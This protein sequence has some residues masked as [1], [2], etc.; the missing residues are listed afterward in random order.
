MTAT[1]APPVSFSCQDNVAVVTIDSP[2]V[3]AISLAVTEGLG[4]ALAKFE[5]A[6]ELS[7]LVVACAGRTWV[8]GGDIAAFEIPEFSSAPFNSFLAQLEAQ[9]RPVVA[10]LRGT[11]LGGGLEL[12]LACHH[13]VALKDTRF[14]LPEVK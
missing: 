7:A 6:A 13:R 14:G 1:A 12:A 9:S 10:A 3:N 11:V 2:P 5:A 8:A 4:A